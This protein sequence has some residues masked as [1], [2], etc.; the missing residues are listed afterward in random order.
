[1]IIIEFFHL[2]YGYADQDN[3]TLT[4]ERKQNVIRHSQDIRVIKIRPIRLGKFTT[5]KKFYIQVLV[6]VIIGGDKKL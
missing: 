1:L 4:E 2:S 5:N 3:A 6:R